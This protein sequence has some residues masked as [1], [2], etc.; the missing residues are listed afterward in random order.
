M[1]KLAYA[2]ESGMIVGEL[3]GKFDFLSNS[4]CSQK[5]KK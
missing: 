2:D 1:G 3:E 5:T 4:P